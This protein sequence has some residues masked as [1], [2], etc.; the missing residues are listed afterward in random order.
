M[1]I[2]FFLNGKEINLTLEEKQN[3]QVEISIDQRKYKVLVEKISQN[4][5]LLNVEGKVYDVIIHTS[6][7]HYS[8]Y[9]N[10]H[11]Y[12]IEKKSSLKLDNEKRGFARGKKE[13]KTSMPGRV[14]RVLAQEGDNVREGQGI[15][16]LEAM[17]MENEIKSPKSGKLTKIVPQE[18]NSVESGGLLFIVE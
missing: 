1:N 2:V 8:V 4:E 9:V 16:V 13:I 5:L 3:N 14:V 10:G 12:E 17:K 11:L 18:G 6:K 7:L 15:L